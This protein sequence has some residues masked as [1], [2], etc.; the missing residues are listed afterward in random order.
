MACRRRRQTARAVRGPP[1]RAASPKRS[2][3]SVVAVHWPWGTSSYTLYTLLPRFSPRHPAYRKRNQGQKQHG[4]FDAMH[5]NSSI[6]SSSMARMCL[7]SSSSRMSSG[8]GR[9]GM[10][11]RVRSV[12]GTCK[13]GPGERITARSMICCSSRMLPGRG[14]GSTPAW[15]PQEWS[16]SFCACSGRIAG[17]NG[18]RGL[19]MTIH[20][21]AEDSA[22]RVSCSPTS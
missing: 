9:A 12:S 4:C 2:G 10:A 17:R 1:V 14:T 16:R 11:R 8:V 15:C 13:T 22:A 19:P 21:S 5:W 6:V 20:S 3:R 7:R 18:A